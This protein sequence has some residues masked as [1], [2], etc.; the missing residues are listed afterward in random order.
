MTKP[1]RS[2]DTPIIWEHNFTTVESILQCVENGSYCAILG[3]RFS[4]KTAILRHVEKSLGELSQPC[5]YID[6]FK[7]QAPTQMG[8][9]TILMTAIAEEILAHSKRPLVALAE[10][11]S[12]ATFRDFLS[13]CVEHLGSNLT[14]IF[15]HLEEL[16]TDLNRALL[17]SLRALYMEQQDRDLHF[18]AIVS[19]ALSLAALTVGET[20]PFHG[21]AHRMILGELNEEESRKVVMAYTSNTD[22]L[23]SPVARSILLEAT[24]GNSHLI[25]YICK[26][27]IAI[28]AENRSKQIGVHTVKRVIREF[29]RDEAARYEPLQEA[30]RLIEDDPDLLQGILRLVS[31]ETVPR[32]E[33][34]LP[35]HPDLDPLYL[36]GMVEKVG[37]D[38]YRIRN[39]IY[40]SYLGEYFDAARTGHLLAVSGRWDA[41]IGHLESSVVSGHIE[42]RVDLLAATINSMYASETEEKAAYYLIRGLSAAFQV[43]QIAVWLLARNGQTLALLDQKGTTI[44]GA[45]PTNLQEISLNADRIEARSYRQ[46]CILREHQENICN[47]YVIPLLVPGRPPVGIVTLCEFQK[48]D[49][50]TK[51]KS[52]EFQL[53]SFLNQAARALFEVEHRRKREARATEQDRQL[54]E[55]SRQLILLHR[56]STLSQTLDDL[57]KNCHLILTAI[58]AHFGLGFNRAWLFLLDQQKSNLTGRMGIGSLTEDQNYRAWEKTALLSFD[59]YVRLLLSGEMER[60]EIDLTMRGLSIPVSGSSPDLFSMTLHQRHTFRWSGAP[61]HG[62]ALPQEFKQRFEPGEMILTPLVV[63]SHLLGLIVV[64]NKFRPRHY[65]ETDELLLKTFANQMATAL[66]NHHQHEQEKQRLRLEETLRD[67]SLIIGGSLDQKEV[68]H[69]ILEEMKKVLPFDTASIQLADEGTQS[70]QIIANAGF[71]DPEH[72]E[73]LRFPLNDDFPNA[74]VFKR[75]EPLHYDDVQEHFSC[76]ADPHY[77]ATH[78]HGWLGAPLIIN[79]RAIGVITLDS[80]APGIYTTEHDRLAVLFAG[81]ASVAIENAR[82][83]ENEKETREYLELLVGSSQDGILAVDNQGWVVLYSEGAEKILHYTPE[84]VLNNQKRVDEL[85]GSLGIAREINSH[86]LSSGKLRDYETTIVDK[87]HNP[88]PIVLSASLL[89][90]KFGKPLGSVGFFKDLRQLRKVENNLRMILDTVEAMAK[91]SSSEAGLSVLAERIVATRLV[92]F[93]N[94]LLLDDSKQNLVLKVAYPIS[95][96]KEFIW[97]PAVGDSISVTQADLMKHFMELPNASV[98]QNGQVVKGIDVVRHI[99]G[100]VSSDEDMC[101]ALVVPLKAGSEVFGICI[102]G[103]SRSWDRSPFDKEKVELVSSMVTQGSVFVDRLKAYEAMKNKLVMVERLRSIGEDLV[104]ASPDA[105]KSILDKVVQAACEVTGA[106]SAIIYPWDAEMRTYDTNSIVHFGLRKKKSF[107]PKIRHTEGSMTGIVVKKGMVIV[108]DVQKGLDRSGETRVWA[109]EGSFLEQEGVNAFIGISLR[110]R[111]DALGGLFVN[112]Q[113]PH[114]FSDSEL[115]AV[116]LFANQAAIAIENAR[117]YDDLHL[118]L[119]ESNILLEEST[120]LQKVGT[121]LTDTRD[122]NSVLDRVLQAVFEL[123]H[124]DEANILFYDVDKDKFR[125]DAL[126]SKGIGQPLEQYKTRTRQHDGYTYK[127]IKSKSHVS[128]SDTTLDSMINPVTLQKGRRAAFG[129]PLIGRESP[130]GVLWIHWKTPHEISKRDERLLTALAGQAAISIENANLFDQLKVENVRRNSESQALQE[131]GISLTE[132]I[133]QNGILHRVFQAALKL[134]DAEEGSI[135]FYDDIRDEFLAEALMCS[136]VGQ[137]LETYKTQVRQR[138]GLAYEIITGRKPITISDTE[139]DPRISKVAIKKGRG[140]TIGV[141]LLDHEGPVGVLWVNWKMPHQVSSGETSLLMTLASLATVAIKGARR[142]AELQRRSAHLEAVHQAGKV[143]S[144]ASVGLDQQQVLDRILEQAIECVTGVSGSKAFVGTI[145]LLDEDTK[146]L[147][148]KSVFPKHYPQHS[149][150][151]FAHINLDSKK[152]QD[153]RIGV[154]GRAALTRESQLVPD[155]NK[156]D[157]YIAHNEETQSELAVPMLDNGKVIGVLD[158]EGREL[159]AFDEMDRDSLKL[160]VD[161]AVVALRNAEQAEQLTRSNSVGLMGAWGAEIVH[162]INREVGFIRREILWLSQQLEL[163]V[164]LLN[165]LEIIDTHAGNLALPEIP[166]RLPGQEAM[167]SPS[168]TDIDSVILS[169]VEINRRNN[170]SISFHFEPGCQNA[171][172]AMHER[173]ILAIFRNLLRNAEHALLQ[174]HSNQRW[175]YVN[176]RV[177]GSM[178]LIEMKNSGPKVRDDIIPY[179][180]KRLI[181]HKDG[182]KGRGLLLVGF[183]VEQHGGRSEVVSNV[184][185]GAFFRF[186]LPLAI[187]S[188]NIEKEE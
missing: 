64:D 155:V 172:V 149:I 15:D 103:E 13:R 116:S 125:A 83:Y 38:N 156:D 79:D 84:E 5:I 179:L 44:E 126:M 176:T 158:V 170:S 162:D 71:D 178:A 11:A 16:P 164:D 169:V 17:I 85:Y 123:I 14:V 43:E 187:P 108:D 88:I 142:Y 21:I 90:D 92:T 52:W 180:F 161:L 117:L 86:L 70:L 39:S 111:K 166:E 167:A 40:R 46:E 50:P 183:L 97:K 107:S 42:S 2:S 56:V 175:V 9:F 55:Q 122:L 75:M 77:R 59:E 98:F 36:T 113:E 168:S 58:T 37:Q 100:L 66:F 124:S 152:H 54:E 31:N 109:R 87:E 41:A 57:E 182:R 20:S 72:V 138:A 12:S 130:V 177:D 34:Q 153:G 93:C 24:R 81:Q 186:W 160:L 29:L 78:I 134:V 7:V 102:L 63:H 94:I 95:R 141:P 19:G 6:L 35:L 181:P 104:T 22:V 3:P 106:S 28:A 82:L 154:S 99:Q 30:V 121:S 80:K 18:V 45:L 128:I 110:T 127:I 53:Q 184:E 118:K 68:L 69:R 48:N 112:F 8:F 171:R 174:D 32:R 1:N 148:V 137:P 114:Y 185:S 47:R 74:Y 129:V 27:S 23:V 131:V 119:E 65:T 173:F 26:R 91:V 25:K 10:E 73:T 144:A 147:V 135:L 4:G 139:Q 33:L 61:E 120:I 163:Q 150:E 62:Y 140:A 101:S 136:G 151:V 188:E 49:A 132:T 133:D 115:E 51:Q 96:K 145:Q 89:R 76:F 60:D 159:N 165:S 143:I 67:T 157:D 105:S 146:E